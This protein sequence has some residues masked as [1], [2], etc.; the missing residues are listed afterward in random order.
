MQLVSLRPL[1]GQDNDS[2]SRASDGWTGGLIRK[3]LNRAAVT[4]R[5][6]SLS[7]LPR[8]LVHLIISPA[9]F[10]RQFVLI[11]LPLS[12]QE[13]FT[14]ECKFKESVFE[15]YYVTYSSMM[16]RQQQ[17]GRAWYLGLNKEGA[18]MKGNHVKKNKA[19][20]HFIPKPLK[21]RTAFILWKSSC[22]AYLMDC[23]L[24][25]GTAIKSIQCL[26]KVCIHWS[27]TNSWAYKF[28]PAFEKLNVFQ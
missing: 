24:N 23:Y 9:A 20:A 1:P 16:Y 28:H 27:S 6:C 18:I 14:P 17:S 5:M 2:K 25:L 13:H 10:L 21:G 19:A 4:K 26:W 7:L 15:N 22:S 3:F 12:S 8:V 11:Y